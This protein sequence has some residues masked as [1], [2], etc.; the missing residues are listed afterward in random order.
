[1]TRTVNA[2]HADGDGVAMSVE[3][4]TLH[5]IPGRVRELTA[6]QAAR[7]LQRVAKKQAQLGEELGQLDTVKSLLTHQIVVATS[8]ASA[9]DRSTRPPWI[10]MQQAATLLLC[11]PRTV[12]RYIGQGRLRPGE[13]WSRT[14]AGRYRFQT[15]AL[16]RWLIETPAPRSDGPGLAF[17]DVPPGRRRR[18]R[19]SA[20]G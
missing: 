6:D 8:T 7:M 5:S 17:A 13:H 10:N 2:G 14:G 19:R 16:E 1:M 20:E 4:M 15:A 11:D 9:P 12:R 3:V 18:R